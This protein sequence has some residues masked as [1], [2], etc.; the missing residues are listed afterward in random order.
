MQD[1]YSFLI[2][3]LLVSSSLSMAM[4]ASPDLLFGPHRTKQE[5]LAIASRVDF[6]NALL[7]LLLRPIWGNAMDSF[8]RKP[9]LVLGCLLSTLA[10]ATTAFNPKSSQAYIFYRL[11]NANSLMPVMQASSLLL[12]DSCGGDR[13][14][15]VYL[16]TSRRLFMM[17]A[18]ARITFTRVAAH[19][20][21]TRGYS[22]G[23]IMLW[24]ARFTLA[25][26]VLFA[27][28]VREKPRPGGIRPPF[29]I[30]KA[31]SSST[32]FFFQTPKRRLLALMLV[33]R[34]LPMACG[35]VLQSV[36]KFAFGWGPNERATMSN[37][38]DFC[39]LA[40]P[41]V[42]DEILQLPPM[43]GNQSLIWG[44]RLSALSL[45]NIAFTPFPKTTW[46]NSIIDRLV[47]S[48][49]FFD[50]ELQDEGAMGMVDA[51][52]ATLEFPVSLCMPP[53]LG[54]V[55][56]RFG[57]RVPFAL[58]ALAHLCLSEGLVSWFEDL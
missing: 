27:F 57:D 56:S 35:S 49:P 54:K 20:A 39:D 5:S 1:Y 37:I 10:R 41:L 19:L 50:R 45:F 7:Q 3:R 32:L 25:S 26:A 52:A 29:S 4:Q 17:L 51:A 40:I 16:Q 55:A 48:Q 43:L 2:A 9:V 58:L 42:V 22:P 30:S 47:S 38:S 6:Y 33:L 28:Q 23:S 36:H 24:A 11:V 18:V 13:N 34:M 46:L 14:S 8:G 21:L 15:A 12:L 53:V 44:S 31:W